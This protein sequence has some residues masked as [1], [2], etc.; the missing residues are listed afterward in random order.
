MPTRDTRSEAFVRQNF[1]TVWPVHLDGF[2]RL[3]VQLRT[4]FEGDLDLALVLAVIGS[5][6]MPGRWTPALT[7]LGRMTDGDRETGN[8][9]PINLQSVADFSGIP[10]ET[11][12]RKV[13]LLQERGWISRATDGCLAV[14]QSAAKDL[15]GATSDT[16][17]Y[18]SSLLLAFEAARTLERSQTEP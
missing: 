18:L 16:I 10:R 2:T 13:K 14:T 6:T 12:R 8:Q 9:A 1:Q 11:V 15:E 3:L 5:R 7:D 4:R 17:T